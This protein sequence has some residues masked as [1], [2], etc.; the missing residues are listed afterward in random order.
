MAD[1]KPVSWM[2]LTEGTEV[3][4]SDGTDLGKVTSVVADTQKDIFSG[5]EFRSGFLSST[6]FA[7]ADLIAEITEDRVTL[8]IT[9]EAAEEL[10]P[11]ES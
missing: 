3:V 6:S 9:A 4:A 2:T 8:T 7:R 5:I 11:G 10:S 1:N